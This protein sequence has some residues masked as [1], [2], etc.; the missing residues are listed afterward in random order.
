MPKLSFLIPS[1]NERFLLQTVNGIFENCSDDIE[2]VVCLDG[3]SWPVPPLPERENLIVIRN[4]E[5]KGT[6]A[7][8]NAC[9]AVASGAYLC[10]IDAHCMVSPGFDKGIV[11]DREADWVVVPLRKRLDAENWQV[12]KTDRP[13]IAYEYLRWHPTD[14]GG[15]GHNITK[16]DEKNVDESLRS[17]LIDDMFC[18]QAS[19]WSVSR[20]Y[21]KFLELMDESTYGKTQN[22]GEEIAFKAWLSGGRVVVNKKFWYAHLHKGNRYPRDYKFEEADLQAGASGVQKWLTDSAWDRQTK[23]FSWLIEKFNPPGWPEGYQPEGKTQPL[24]EPKPIDTLDRIL[25]KFNLDRHANWHEVGMPIGLRMNRRQIAELFAELGFKI[26]AEIGTAEGEYAEVLCKSVPDLK[27][28]CIDPWKTYAGYRDYQKRDTLDDLLTKAAARLEG[29][30][31]EF[32]Q[33]YSVAAAQLIEDESLDFV[34]VDANH[35]YEY[36]VADIAAWLP[37]IKHG[38]VLAGHDYSHPKGKQFGVVEAVQGW[39]NAYGVRPWFTLKGDYEAV[40]DRSHS[41]MFVKTER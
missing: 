2:I 13:D 36:V 4:A 26:G 33:A 10:K 40:G 21:Y 6:R 8:I 34:Y 29:L 3:G 22:E 39:V 25:H 19:C 12:E 9:A 5:P 16:W 30:N 24:V 1:R 37:K 32:I 20:E 23:P 38:G 35:K 15:R 18:M 7:A 17:K 28:Y 31:V 27:L 41:W 14:I 11:T